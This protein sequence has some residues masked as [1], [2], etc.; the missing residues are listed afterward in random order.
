MSN[1][2]R[3]SEYNFTQV[4]NDFIDSKMLSAPLSL[5]VLQ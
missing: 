5:C 3:E 2:F 1:T 4:N